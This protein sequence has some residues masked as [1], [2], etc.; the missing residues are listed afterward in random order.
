MTQLDLENAEFWDELCGSALARSLGVTD[1]SADS[2]HRFDQAYFANYPYLARHLEPLLGRRGR[3]L[4]IGLGYG[5]VGA[6]LTRGGVD[7]YGLDVARGP[8][9]MMRG[10]LAQMDQGE[11]AG[12][13]VQGSALEIPWPDAHFD[14]VVSIGCLHHTGDLRTA[15]DEVHRALV[16]GGLAMVMVYNRDSLRQVLALRP[17]AALQRLR[18]QPGDDRMRAAYDENAAG[19]PPPFTEFTSVRGARTLFSNFGEVRVD[20]ENMDPVASLRIPRE[21]LL[22]WPARLLGLDLYVTAVK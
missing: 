8:V 1:A 15:V 21:R 6:Y 16:P 12:H 14:A 11:R 13:V 9:E 5:T 2:L 20:R 4:E 18:R 10:R 19:E 17:R 7:Y 3:T 22:G